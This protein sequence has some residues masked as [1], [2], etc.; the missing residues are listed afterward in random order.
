GQ[1]GEGW[2]GGELKG[3]SCCVPLPVPPAQAGEGTMWHCLS[4][5]ARARH[6]VRE[7]HFVTC[8]PISP[9][10]FASVLML[11]Y[12]LPA[13]GSAAWVSVSVAVPSIGLATE[14][15]T[16]TMT[17]AV[18][19]GSAGPWKSAAGALPVR[20]EYVPCTSTGWSQ[21]RNCPAKIRYRRCWLAAPIARRS[22]W[23]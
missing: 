19:S 9:R 11:E 6:H 2:G 3:L 17:P 16:G 4:Q 14:P 8:P 15:W 22:G 12:H 7:C 18:L 5:S 13:K 21:C 20:P 10:Q 23:L 1:A